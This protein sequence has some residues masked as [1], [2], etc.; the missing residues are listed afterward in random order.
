[1]PPRG[2]ARGQST[3]AEPVMRVASSQLDN[4]IGERLTLGQEL[5]DGD[6][7][8]SI[9]EVRALKREFRT[10][11][12]FNEQLLRSRF[13]TPKVANQYKRVSAGVGE[14]APDRELYWTHETIR[15]QMRRLSSIRQQ[16]ELY[17]SEVAEDV[18]SMSPVGAVVGS[19]IFL[20]H[21]HD[22][23]VKPQ[24]AEF[25]EKITGERPVI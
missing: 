25:L 17:E 15:D 23:D 14:L 7:Q 2:Q 3:E 20:V 24:V 4:E 9:D 8:P 22:G 6:V 16:L 21:G 11:D 1:M 19:K 18:R 13:T 5:L 12:E 10:W